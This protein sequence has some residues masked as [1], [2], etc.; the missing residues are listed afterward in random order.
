M[1]IYI[2][3]TASCK[4]HY[5]IYQPC[6]LAVVVVIIMFPIIITNVIYTNLDQAKSQQLHQHQSI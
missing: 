5:Q 3:P 1:R 6:L 4:L 2:Q